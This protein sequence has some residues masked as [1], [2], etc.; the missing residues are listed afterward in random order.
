MTDTRTP[1]VDELA[2]RLD[3]G[4]PPK[5]ASEPVRWDLYRAGN[6][7]WIVRLRTDGQ[8]SFHNSDTIHGALAAAVEWKP[9]PII[10]PPPKRMHANGFVPVKD[11]S[12]WRLTYMG[13]DQAIRVK[14]R[15]E[16]VETAVKLERYSNAAA[17]EWEREHGWSR[18]AT[19]GVDFVYQ[20]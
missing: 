13:R 4:Y 3:V 9:L 17:D 15:R 19:E 10:P 5:R 16:A 11:G 6:G 18:N 8:D 14:T 20:D 2:A 12:H 1:T 7:D